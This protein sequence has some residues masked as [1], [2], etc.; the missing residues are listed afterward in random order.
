VT[1]GLFPEVKTFEKLGVQF[2]I[3]RD[4]EKRRLERERRLAAVQQKKEERT[5]QEE[6]KRQEEKKEAQPG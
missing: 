3:E 5:R 2:Q 1:K 6:L 4:I